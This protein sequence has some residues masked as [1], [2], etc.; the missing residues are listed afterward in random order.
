MV[1]VVVAED[2]ALVRQGI[3]LLLGASG[4]FELVA[5][6]AMGSEVE[7][8]VQ[9]HRPDLLLLDLALSDSSGIEV[10]RKVKRAEPRTRI[11]VVTGNVYP[12]SVANAFAAGADGF[13]LKHE[14][15]ADLLEA[16]YTVLAGRR[17]ISPQVAKALGPSTNRQSLGSDTSQSLT[18]R[19]QQI[20]R[21][22]AKGGSNQDI[23]DALHISV[24][25][26]RKH[27]QNVMLKLGLH[28]GAEIAAYAIK[29][30]LAEAPDV[31]S[32]L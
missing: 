29:S 2:H 8:L 12:G 31:G 14:Q 9:H 6:T 16:I 7:L 27:R 18:G 1:K 25:T 28:N 10:A 20:V 22:I 32:N 26:A 19:E 23:A 4:G 24:L 15:G 5:E 13:V 17:Y 21:M 11:L 3:G 30:G